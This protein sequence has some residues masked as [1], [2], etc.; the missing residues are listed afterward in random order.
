MLRYPVATAKRCFPH[1]RATE[2]M[3]FGRMKGRAVV[4][5]IAELFTGRLRWGS[6]CLVGRDRYH[7]WDKTV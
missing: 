5:I 2:K 4:L 6:P 7:R 3:I 1:V